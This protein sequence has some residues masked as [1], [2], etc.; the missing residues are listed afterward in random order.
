MYCTDCDRDERPDD[1]GMVD[2]YF[3]RR[4]KDYMV[5]YNSVVAILVMLPNPPALIAAQMVA[6]T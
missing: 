6:S 4:M 1:G 2:E 5:S 3:S